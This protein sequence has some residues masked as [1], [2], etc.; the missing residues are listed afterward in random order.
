MILALSNSFRI[1]SAAALLAGL[2]FLYFSTIGVLS[3]SVSFTFWMEPLMLEER[4]GVRL[5]SNWL[6]LRGMVHLK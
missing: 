3:A 1:C 5:V 4:E 2:M 6:L